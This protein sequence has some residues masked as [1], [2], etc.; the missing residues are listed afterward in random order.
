MGDAKKREKDLLGEL[1]G[2][3]HDGD[4]PGM[5]ELDRLI[6]RWSKPPPGRDAKRSEAGAKA[7]RSRSVKRKRPKKK[8][9]THYLATET[10]NELDQAKKAIRSLA[11]SKIRAGI[12]KSLIVDSALKLL[13]EDFEDK[14][15]DSILLQKILKE[16]QQRKK[17]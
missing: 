13:L 17:S 5:D 1:L 11:P 12:S 10:F 6:H 4:V 15:E 14:G 16:K 7:T 9:S 2:Q 8:K 3:E